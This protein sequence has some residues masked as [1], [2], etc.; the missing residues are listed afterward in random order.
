[1]VVT[2]IAVTALSY[3]LPDSAAAT[4]VGLAFLAATYLVSLRRDHPLGP[5]HY[6]LALGGLLEPEPLSAKRILRDSAVALA[7][8]LLLAAIF[9]PPFW[10]GY[11]AWWKPRHAFIAAAL[12]SL[13]DD[14]LGQLF[15]IALPEEAFYRGYLQTAFD[16]AFKRRWRLLGAD[17]GPGLLISAALFA[18][19]H[20]LT[21]VHPNRLAVF[22]PA[23]VFGWLRS[24]T[25]G[26]G[27]G[28]AFHALCNLFAAYLA[29]SYGMG[30]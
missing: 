8:A 14:V 10:L 5:S 7:W 22:F 19:G 23:L 20:F 26:V 9:Y 11:L 3:L 24:R 15:V 17:V 25:K 16:D 30:H 4:G 13:A 12:P 6:G 27:A 18:L 1:V 21:E 2:T 28:V 29:R